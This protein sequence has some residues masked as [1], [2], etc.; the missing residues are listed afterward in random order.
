[1]KVL[2]SILL[3]S[4]FVVQYPVHSITINLDNASSE[5]ECLE[6]VED[7]S[8]M[9]NEGSDDKLLAML[10][11]AKALEHKRKFKSAVDL[12][13]KVQEL[14][15]STD[16]DII[17]V[18]AVEIEMSANQWFGFEFFHEA[19]ER[20]DE[21]I[22]SSF[23]RVEI[24]LRTYKIKGYVNY[25][26]N[27]KRQ[28]DD[29]VN[30]GIINEL[31]V[32]WS[33]HDFLKLIDQE[34]STILNGKNNAL[35]SESEI[36]IISKHDT[37][38]GAYPASLIDRM[39]VT[40]IDALDVFDG[41]YQLSN[42]SFYGSIPAFITLYKD[43]KEWHPLLL[44]AKYYALLLD[45]Q[46]DENVVLK[47]WFDLQRLQ[48]LFNT[49]EQY[50]K[51]DGYSQALQN[52][53]EKAISTS[54]IAAQWLAQIYD[55]Y[56]RKSFS[57]QKE[58]AA[59]NWQNKALQLCEEALESFP[60]S[61]GATGC[62]SFIENVKQVSVGITGSQSVLPNHK[63]PFKISYKNQQWV[64]L[65]AYAVNSRVFLNYMS[66]NTYWEIEKAKPI[67]QETVQFPIAS[68]FFERSAT[69]VL[70]ELNTGHYV[71][72]AEPEHVA[73]GN[74]LPQLF[75]TS[76]HLSCI[77]K[78][79]V[80][81]TEVFVD[82]LVSGEQVKE[83]AVSLIDRNYN[84][85]TRM[86]Y[87]ETKQKFMGAN[88]RLFIAKDVRAG[89]LAVSKGGDT[90]ITRFSHN[91]IRKDNSRQSQQ[92]KFFTDRSIYRPGQVV[93]FKGIS[94]IG[95]DDEFKPQSDVQIAVSFVGTGNKVI[96]ERSFTTN[97]FGSFW[98]SFKIPESARPGRM[99]LR[100]K[101]GSAYFD[102]QNYK[103]PL[104][105]AKYIEN[106]RVVLPSED[107]QI[108]LEVK[109]FAGL[110]IQNAKVEASIKVSSGFF[111]FWSFFKDE[112]LIGIVNSETNKEGVANINFTSLQNKYVQH[113]NITATVT[114]PD[115]AMREF[116]HTYTV[117]P[118]P[119]HIRL[120]DRS[121]IQSVLNIPKVSIVGVNGEKITQNITVKV[122]QLDEPDDY[123]YDLKIGKSD[124]VL[125]D[126]HLWGEYFSGAAWHHSL[127]PERMP[128][129]KEVFVETQKGHEFSKLE[130]LKL[131]EG[132]YAFEFWIADTL[133]STIYQSFVDPAEKSVKFA[134]P[135]YLVVDK[136]SVVPGD[137]VTVTMASRL[138]NAH[139][140]LF[141]TDKDGILLDKAIA[142][143]TKKLQLPIEIQ[144]R[145][146]GK[147]NLHAIVVHSGQLFE[148]RESIDVK[149]ISRSIDVEITSIRDKIIPGDN[150][151]WTLKLTQSGK[152][153]SNA[154]VL[155]AMYD[156]SLDEFIPHKWQIPFQLSFYRSYFMRAM[157][158]DLVYQ[159]QY[160]S[161]GRV[162]NNVIDWSVQT[163]FDHVAPPRSMF[164]R[165]MAKDK[166]AEGISEE[167][168]SS[169]DNE[170]FSVETTTEEQNGASQ[171]ES[172]T[173]NAIRTNFNETAFFYPQLKS[174]ENGNVAVKFTAPEAMSRW[175][176]QI[177]AHNEQMAAGYAVH[178]I[179]T[180]KPLMI[181]P[182]Q[183]R[184]LHHQD[185]VSLLS[186]AFNA[187]DSTIVI[188][189]QTQITNPV[190]GAILKSQLSDLELI[191]EGGQSKV[192]SV[193]FE[194]PDNLSALQ[195]LISGKSGRYTDGELHQIPVYP[196]RQR[197][198]NSLV[199]WNKPNENK[200]YHLKSL[201]QISSETSSNHQLLV[202]L[203]T[204]PLWFAIKAMPAVYETSVKS[205]VQLAQNFYITAKGND[206]IHQYPEIQRV[207]KVWKDAQPE[208]L[209]S[210]FAKNEDLKNLLVGQ[211]PWEDVADNEELQHAV[212]M[213]MLNPNFI[214]QNMSS[215]ISDL[216]NQQMNDGAFSWRPGMRPSWYFTLQTVWYLSQALHLSEVEK[217]NAQNIVRKALEYLD[218]E[219]ELRYQN[220]LRYN[221]DTSK[222]VTSTDL[223][224][225][226][227]V[228]FST[229]SDYKPTTVAEQ[230][231]L[232]H[233][234]KYRQMG[235][236]QLVMSGMVNHVAGNEKYAKLV[237]DLL[238][239]RSVVDAQKG[240]YWRNNQYGWQWE[241]API[242]TQSMIIKYF[243]EMKQPK[244][245]LEAMKMWLIR[246]KQGQ[247]WFDAQSSLA[248]IDALLI[249]GKEWI[250]NKN[251]VVG[252]IGNL[253][254]RSSDEMQE[255]GTGYFRK[256]LGVPVPEMENAQVDN[257]GATPI[258]GAFYHSF[259]E[260]F[261]A[262]KPWQ[263]ELSIERKLFVVKATPKGEVVENIKDN[264][265]LKIG[266]RVRVQL[267]LHSNR[268]LDF[269][270]V[271]CP[272]AACF[273]PVEHLSGYRWNGGMS[274]YLENHDSEYR[275][276]FD[277]FEK[278]DAVVSY[279]LFVERDGTYNAGAAKIQSIYAP[280]FGANSAGYSIN[281]EK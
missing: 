276:F 123:F 264:S 247:A 255:A 76:T 126:E 187:T 57:E 257:N 217:T 253:T 185:K 152:T 23:G 77:T 244:N 168:E 83:F 27:N 176:F 182:N 267:T 208:A 115:G 7:Y 38:D 261:D 97:D 131:K 203:T 150:E 50:N 87:F 74:P 42:Q 230:F 62:K 100:T 259:L 246:E 3:F 266:D 78:P 15:R 22:A 174:D 195:Y 68:G 238:R 226:F 12:A 116:K 218:A 51:L 134:E 140:K 69:V 280:E 145:S 172:A 82:Y 49:D 95:F 157:N 219:V 6:N 198:V 274:Y 154:E 119:I 71:L 235:L 179:V 114:T 241:D 160:K 159:Q 175:K 24:L 199:I 135:F 144:D 89:F 149:P 256:S 66:N 127:D 158:H 14:A 231:F 212:L 142:L 55:G 194:V 65:S 146:E 251:P 73:S 202:E 70:P 47:N 141:I 33:K 99:Q 268:N 29:N 278:G 221:V 9:D 200:E 133:Y 86:S 151:L 40:T 132:L 48:N 98:G 162:Q 93:H 213:E 248:A 64:K 223:L 120:I 118:N 270:A 196:S 130:E 105:D 211:T 37:F 39:F 279:D 81:R 13:L 113:Y 272:R 262:I 139:V 63:I 58:V 242:V 222:Y 163:P 128:I 26:V 16:N 156:I 170:D 103:R 91:Y 44:K 111:R 45:R 80:E 271:T 8:F 147:I 53:V 112:S 155:A 273:E 92:V 60:K 249:N 281:V 236:Q 104:F 189:P 148:V 67:W 164:M 224:K 107:V 10:E 31:P 239:Q 153:L 61:D 184:F 2:L 52:H 85:Q 94:A 177:L 260:Q 183:L 209:Q 41:D 84:R 197:I 117:S 36:K 138:K 205:A 173:N 34:V 102:V 75:I 216:E 258:W 32:Q 166:V 110:A 122:N 237:I 101:G 72:V 228:K 43:N 125:V 192:F 229:N 233:S 21:H 193:E 19:I 252:K 11:E 54:T 188:K 1:M 129:K 137:I 277:R 18:K 201:A 165:T 186:T 121:P 96:E 225:Y 46:S 263:D 250:E 204:N 5:K 207:F 56:A 180:Q 240:I 17:Y 20:L 215:A 243:Y 210:S 191:V 59:V 88:G 269:I 108:K 109:S 245:E 275:F 190:T 169:P 28:L 30:D 143:N 232:Q 214:D 79:V 265:Q 220:M 4:L 254:I 90:L 161:I 206:I 106:E 181:I 227:Q 25:Y 178:E 167:R 35:L 136:S 234:V 124:F 171:K